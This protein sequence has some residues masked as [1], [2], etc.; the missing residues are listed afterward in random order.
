MMTLSQLLRACRRHVLAAVP[1]RASQLHQQSAAHRQ[2][3]STAGILH[4]YTRSI[5][6]RTQG[7]PASTPQQ[8]T[9]ITASRHP[10]TP[11]AHRLLSEGSLQPDPTQLAAVQA[12]QLLQ[13]SLLVQLVQSAAAHQQHDDVQYNNASTP[14]DDSTSQQQTSTSTHGSSN[15]AS[16]SSSSS[17]TTMRP[18]QSL[19]PPSSPPVQGAYLWG[20]VGRL[21]LIL[22]LI[23]QRATDPPW[24]S[25]W[26]VQGVHH[27][28]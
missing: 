25:S 7:L 23:Q 19:P 8:N 15:N 10:L 3:S 1:F 26:L 6:Y 2:L 12:L 9:P 20:P 21:R 17:S 14:L 28:T 27:T 5:T 22:H 18:P 13:D 11:I 4:E 24:G 16:T